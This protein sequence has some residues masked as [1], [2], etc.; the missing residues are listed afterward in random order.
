MWWCQPPVKEIIWLY[1][2][3]RQCQHLPLKELNQHKISVNTTERAPQLAGKHCVSCSAGD[4]IFSAISL[5]CR[6]D[7]RCQST[8]IVYNF[9]SNAGGGK[10]VCFFLSLWQTF[11]KIHLVQ[12]NWEDGHWPSP[13]WLLVPGSQSTSPLRTSQNILGGRAKQKIVTRIQYIFSQCFLYYKMWLTIY[14]KST[15]L[16]DF[17]LLSLILTG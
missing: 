13:R 15:L 6:S 4:S 2:R 3:E 16:S 5:A 10:W 7:D 17:S 9:D 1:E 12:Q 8:P 14:C 11:C